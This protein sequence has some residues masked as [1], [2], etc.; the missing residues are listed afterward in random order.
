MQKIAAQNHRKRAAFVWFPETSTPTNTKLAAC[1]I[2]DVQTPT[3]W[4]LHWEKYKQ[5]LEFSTDELE[6]EVAHAQILRLFSQLTDYCKNCL[7]NA[8]TLPPVQVGDRPPDDPTDSKEENIQWNAQ[9][10]QHLFLVFGVLNQWKCWTEEIGDKFTAIKESAVVFRDFSLGP[11]LQNAFFVWF[12]NRDDMVVGAI[13]DGYWSSDLRSLCIRFLAVSSHAWNRV[14]LGAASP[15]FEVFQQTCD[16][17]SAKYLGAQYDQILDH[18]L[19][20]NSDVNKTL[21]TLLGSSHGL[22]LLTT[23]LIAQ[24]EETLRVQKK[25]GLAAHVYPQKQLQ[26]KSDRPW[27]QT[28]DAPQLDTAFSQMSLGAIFLYFDKL[29]RNQDEFEW[30]PIL[31]IQ[32]TFVLLDCLGRFFCMTPQQRRSEL[33]NKRFGTR[34]L[35]TLGKTVEFDDVSCLGV[36]ERWT[37]HWNRLVWL[38]V[39]FQQQA[40]LVAHL[41][42]L[43]FNATDQQPLDFEVWQTRCLLTAESCEQWEALFL[44]QIEQVRRENIGRDVFKE[45]FS[46]VSLGYLMLPADLEMYVET[47]DAIKARKPKEV[48]QQT[49]VSEYGELITLLYNPLAPVHVA[50]VAAQSGVTLLAEYQR[51]LQT[52]QDQSASKSA[53]S[54]AS[55]PLVETRLKNNV[56]HKMLPV[57]FKEILQHDALKRATGGDITMQQLEKELSQLS[58]NAYQLEQQHESLTGNETNYRSFTDLNK[59]EAEVVTEL[60]GLK[61]GAERRAN[62]LAVELEAAKEKEAAIADAVFKLQQD[63]LLRKGQGGGGQKSSKTDEFWTHLFIPHYGLRCFGPVSSLEKLE[64]LKE[65]RGAAEPVGFH[66]TFFG[67][68]VCNR[69]HQLFEQVISENAKSWIVFLRGEY[70]VWCHAHRWFARTRNLA[71][72]VRLYTAEIR[73]YS[74]ESIVESQLDPV[75]RLMYKL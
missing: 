71:A 3:I 58:L 37:L 69:A 56:Y 11:F 5:I 2:S 7:E 32:T 48:L 72:A 55:D 35:V 18:T 68:G 15:H 21:E 45:A 28:V 50:M 61:R 57:V 67:T 46:Q 52:R 26:A 41:D 44:Q 30:L 20:V 43:Q 74:T 39:T 54:V 4:N 73:F 47:N 16:L 38:R 66:Q 8:V 6:I 25:D 33:Y 24:N 53:N 36:F 60:K 13:K 59:D 65:L 34:L 1:N 19:D 10:L 29:W 27:N 23:T 64:H 75:S 63:Y 62:L 22:P 49:R 17:F 9:V 51:I 31:E 12:T 40:A 42:H 70:W 14:I